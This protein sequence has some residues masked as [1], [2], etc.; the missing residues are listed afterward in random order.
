MKSIAEIQNF[1][2]KKVIVRVD[3]NVPHEGDRILD[4]SR[5]DIT[6]E[7]IRWIIGR[8]GSA[9][10]ISHFGRERE[11]MEHISKLIAEILPLTF[12]ADPF[13]DDGKSKISNIKSGE[14]ILLENIRKWPEEEG[15]DEDFAKKMSEFGD[16]Y[17][18]EAFSNSHRKHASM[19]GI[20]KFLPRFAG[21]NLLK[22]M[23][24]LSKAFNPP[25]PFLFILGGAKFE[26][27]MP[28]VENFL[29]IADDIFIGGANAK[30]ASET[31]LA[32][33]PKIIF[34]RGDITALDAN[35]ETI[36]MLKEKA[37]NSKFILWSG[38]LGKYEDGYKKGTEVLAKVLAEVATQ[39]GVEVIV[40]GGDTE[41]CISSL[42]IKEKFA[43][44]SL[45]GG[46]MLAYL[47]TRT[48]PAIEALQ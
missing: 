48:L 14:V 25:H 12:V 20:P 39:R 13:A 31:E 33:N 36:E 3:W 10:V 41:E 44:V 19:V 40:G 2:N 11:S 46:A 34:P 8:G 6:L 18:N 37:I 21:L 27:K 47:A 22:E 42:G 17:V 7:T 9:I 32:Q 1:E 16:I 35:A 30:P 5:I 29:D 24:H 45:A 4:T 38:P 15:N 23:E 26:T 28:L 43:W